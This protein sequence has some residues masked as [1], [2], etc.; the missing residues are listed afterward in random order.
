MYRNFFTNTMHLVSLVAAALLCAT[1]Q[2]AVQE[3]EVVHLGIAQ[4]QGIAV[5]GELGSGEW[6][7]AGVVTLEVTPHWNVPIRYK[8]RDAS[9]RFLKAIGT[10]QIDSKDDS[11]RDS[12][13]NVSM[14]VTAGARKE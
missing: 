8:R 1:A 13:G 12:P 7:D 5:D 14:K 6:N 3:Q 11:V 2:T 9:R 4:G 10:K